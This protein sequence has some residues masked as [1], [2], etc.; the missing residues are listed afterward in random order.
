MDDHIDYDGSYSQKTLWKYSNSDAESESSP[1]TVGEILKQ[2]YAKVDKVNQEIELL[3][4]N[5]EDFPNQIAQIKLT[6]DDILIKVESLDE[7]DDMLIEEMAKLQVF[8][9]S[10]LAQ[11]EKVTTDVDS[12]SQKLE[13]VITPEKLTISIKEVLREDGVDSITTA[14]GYTFD[15]EGLTITKAG[16]EMST[17][18]T[19][20]GMTVYRDKEAV[21]IAN[22]TGVEAT[23]LHAT[24]YLVIG[25]ISHFEEYID[26]NGRTR[27]GCFWLLD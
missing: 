6:V 19:E 15:S 5:V 16:T 20:D 17:Q 13:T 10:I 23:N 18:I 7:Q 22:N 4:K 26:I 2:T 11:V 21:L 3:V 14:T 24:T 12:M 27:I 25:G 1:A 9:D 8:N